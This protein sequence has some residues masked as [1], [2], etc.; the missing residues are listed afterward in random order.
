MWAMG[1]CFF[2]CLPCIPYFIDTFHDVQHKCGNCGALL[3]TFLRSGGT[4]VHI[5]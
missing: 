5:Q 3:A 2:T 1:F 4:T